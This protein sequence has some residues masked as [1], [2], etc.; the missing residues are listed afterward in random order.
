MD[1]GDDLAGEFGLVAAKKG[2]DFYLQADPTVA[3]IPWV[4]SKS[5]K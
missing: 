3:V 4:K 5:E 2:I 1:H